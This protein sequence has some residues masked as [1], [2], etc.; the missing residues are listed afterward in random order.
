MNK[1]RRVALLGSTG[2]IGRSTLEVMARH[3]D[4]FRAVCLA[5]GRNMDLLVEQI[6]RFRPTSVAVRGRE[7]G[8]MLKRRFADLRVF[9]GG[10][11]LEDLVG[12]AQVDT[13]VA[14]TDGTSALRAT[15]RSIR[16]NRRLCLA[17]KE[18]LVAAGDLVNRELER[19]SGELIPID[20]EQS[21]IFQSLGE[22]RRENLRRV[23]LTASGGPFHGNPRVD[24][25]RI[26]PKEALAH[27]TWNMGR[28]ITVDSSTLMNKALEVIEA[29]HLFRLRKDQIDVVIHPQSI[30][31]SLVE[32][33]DASV[34]AQLGVP[35]MGIPILFSLSYPERL[36]SGRTELD[37]TEI[38]QL[39]FYPL[40]ETR[41]PSIRMAREVLR[42]GGSAGAVFNA[43]NEVA[44]D[45][46]LDGRIG[47][48]DIF[49]VVNEMLDRG[50]FHVLES[51]D[52][53]EEVI[54]STRAKTSELIDRSITK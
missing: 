32:F 40:D 18:T 50:E 2:S 14:A 13:V 10:E 16:L 38:G 53:V 35:D 21:A 46:F 36:D 11:G 27:P 49:T 20:S 47:F 22:N 1:T 42:I 3:P 17:N 7:D 54:E 31:H 29:Y 4:R 33:V 5:A 12:E 15:L 6:Q 25:A 45:R 41:F 43:A 9:H 34:I 44:V 24:L 28:K 26:S 30:V 37:L 8:E 51:V 23:V 39:T 19:N 48:L 52:D